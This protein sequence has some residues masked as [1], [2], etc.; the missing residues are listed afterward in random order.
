MR[1]F[2]KMALLAQIN[3]IGNFI[4][5][6]VVEIL[7]QAITLL[8]LV[9]VFSYTDN[10]KGWTFDSSVFVFYL[11]IVVVLTAECFTTSIN[12]YYR[13][14]AQGRLDPYLTLPVQRVKLMIL[15]W[16]EPGYLIPVV[17]VL[18]L[19]PLVDPNADRS[20][21]DWAFGAATL[22]L[23]VAAIVL[24]FALMSLATLVTQCLTPADFM[25]SEFSHMLFLPVGVY[26]AGAWRFV[27][28]IGFPMLF[29]AGAAA[30]ILV[31]GSYTPAVALALGV[32]GLAAL[33]WRVER[34]LLRNYS[35]PGS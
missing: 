22:A 20:V 26:P 6:I 34:W 16:S 31:E 7:S 23:G 29:G 33:H 27:I 19:W 30:A 3:Y 2:L 13:I 8:F 24:T 18:A 17:V 1:V 32:A 10:I 5:H 28:G 35:Y 14:L 9:T 25:I 12:S 21:V 11:A 4:G 15:R